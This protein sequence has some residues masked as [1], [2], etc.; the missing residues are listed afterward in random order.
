VASLA[1]AVGAAASADTAILPEA[2]REFGVSGVVE[3]LS[4]GTSIST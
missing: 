1:F 2:A 4:I 3:S